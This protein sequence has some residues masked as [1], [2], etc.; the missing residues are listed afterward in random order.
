MLTRGSSLKN[1]YRINYRN[2]SSSSEA[3]AGYESR[4]NSLKREY[5]SLFGSSFI[6]DQE[7][8]LSSLN[9]NISTLLPK[10]N[11]ACD[12]I[13]SN[14]GEN[15]FIKYDNSNLPLTKPIYTIIQKDE[16]VQDK[17]NIGGEYVSELISI[18]DVDGLS[19]EDANLRMIKIAGL[20]DKIDDWRNRLNDDI[21]DTT[22]LGLPITDAVTY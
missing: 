14:S 5:P 10:Y 16:Q 21:D 13:D 22:D 4:I 7:S 2:F 15:V 3:F 17:L 19:V 6:S 18:N 11:D 1:F 9:S 8:L 20:A 12:S